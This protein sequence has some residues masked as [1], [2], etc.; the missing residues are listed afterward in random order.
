MSSESALHFTSHRRGAGLCWLCFWNP[1]NDLRG[2][3][4]TLM[5]RFTHIGCAQRESPDQVSPSWPIRTFPGT[6][7]RHGG[8]G[9]AQWHH[10]S[11]L[12]AAATAGYRH[13]QAWV[14][15][16]LPF[17]IKW[18]LIITARWAVRQ[19]DQ[20]RASVYDSVKRRSAAVT[21]VPFTNHLFPFM[22]LVSPG[23]AVSIQSWMALRF[24]CTPYSRSCPAPPCCSTWSCASLF[25]ENCPTPRRPPWFG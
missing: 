11:S 15:R 8:I 13:Y 9:L 10:W 14:T 24:A 18:P 3:S 4:L 22:I 6:S 21:K 16:R 1:S 23:F 5:S 2:S 19:S 25:I 7:A 20:V 12:L 17:L